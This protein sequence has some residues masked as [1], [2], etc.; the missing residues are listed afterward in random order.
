MNELRKVSSNPHIRMHIST[1]MIMLCVIIALLP[2]T[3]FGIWNFG[4]HAL[5]LILVTIAS[6]VL[7]EWIFDLIC[8]KDNTCL[9]Y[10]SNH[11]Q[12]DYTSVSSETVSLLYTALQYCAVSDGHLDITIAPVK[13]LWSFDPDSGNSYVPASSRCV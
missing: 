9:L 3:I 12:G 8:K 11:A 7:G 6:T 5:V 4:L 2:T 13:A 10:T 1:Q